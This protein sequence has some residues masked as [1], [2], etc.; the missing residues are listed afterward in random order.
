[1]SVRSSMS[2]LISLVRDLIADP[3]G[4]TQQFSDQRVQ[5]AL[6]RSR[7]DVYQE[8]LRWP[9]EIVNAASTDNMAKYVYADFYS[10]HK[11]WES[12]ATLQGYLSSAYWKVLT[13][14]ASEPLVG[15]WQFQT[16]IFTTGTA[17]GQLPPVYITGKIYDP[18]RVAAD[19]LEMW[20]AV[21]ARR[22][23]FTGSGQTLNRSQAAA[24]MLTQAKQYRRQQRIRTSKM[25]RSDMA[26]GGDYGIR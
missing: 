25:V 19:L 2:D 6:D 21:W 24:M 14:V 11:Y 3:A 4:P 12:D 15:H 10:C 5:D 18:Y 23:D 16:S 13:P 8:E 20:A 17:P 9:N 7:D 26:G 1:M 22:Y